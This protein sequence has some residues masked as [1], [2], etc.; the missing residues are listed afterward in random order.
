MKIKLLSLSLFAAVIG[1][2][3]VAVTAQVVAPQV[4]SSVSLHKPDSLLRIANAKSEIDY[5]IPS[6]TLLKMAI[7]A[8]NTDSAVNGSDLLA[9][10][11][12]HLKAKETPFSIVVNIYEDPATEMAFTWFTNEGVETGNVEIVKGKNIDPEHF[13]KPLK[14]AS[15]INTSV[16]D[17]NY[18]TKANALSS[19]AGIADNGKKNY[20]SHKAIVTG[21]IPNTTYSF[22]VGTEGHWS[23]TGTF[24]T[25]AGEG[26]GFSFIYTTDPQA[27][28][29]EMFDIS[30]KTT[31]AAFQKYPEANFW[32]NCGD[33]VQTNGK[34]NAEWEWEQ[35]F[36][37]QQ[38]L[39]LHRPFT[40]VLGNHDKS[41]NRN[42]TNHF[43]TDATAFDAALST[44]PGSVYSFVYGN[45]LFLAF[46]FEDYDKPGYLEALAKWMRSQVEAHKDLKWRIAFYHKTI[47]TGS[48]SHHDDKDSKTIRDRIAPL[49]DSL[50]ID[51]AL[52]GH[53]H[54]YEVI[55]P[56][57]NNKIVPGSVKNQMHVQVDPRENLTGLM[58]G[59][60]DLRQG[61]LFFLNNSSGKKKYEPSAKVQ[62]DNTEADLGVSDYYSLFS[63]RFG[64][65]GRPTFSNISVKGNQIAI[66]TYEVSD[67]GEAKLLDEIKLVK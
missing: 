11:L 62:M 32:L 45:A 42:F 1:L 63:G 19:L 2:L 52:Q 22:R 36:Q 12:N 33:L 13:S 58:K 39:F 41:E 46:S 55:G 30:Q 25:A 66:T 61:T 53:D 48:T 67:T 9:N 35:L 40:P 64:Q 56:V 6:F 27:N 21:L 49:M 34:N 17:L 44:S 16:H 24:K 8:A 50:K 20:V 31:H 51:L 28:T 38:D 15:S 65:T 29:V 4:H 60:F 3:P 57:K 26:K 7:V 5:S 59:T 10:A 23:D 47:Y 18:C 37:T 54:I 43:N 14:S